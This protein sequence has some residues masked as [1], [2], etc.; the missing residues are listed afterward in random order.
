MDFCQKYDRHFIGQGRN[1]VDHARHYI[2]GLMGT[3][4]RKNMETIENDVVGSDYQGLEQ[5]I[6]SSP[7]DHRS[8]P[9]D[10]A[11]D[12]DQAIGDDTEAGF[13]LDETSFLKKGK[14]SVGV[15]RQWSGR[16]GKVEN[17]Q[18]GVFASLGRNDGFCLMDFQ[19][20][21]PES[22]AEDPDRCAKAK[23]PGDRRLYQP[24]W[25]QALDPV[26]RA[27][28][29]KGQIRLGGS[30]RPLRKQS[31]VSQRP[32]GFRRALHGGHPL[33]SQGMAGMSGA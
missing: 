11:R 30:R 9:D 32:G 18:V 29:N 16:A 21:L 19:P 7:W 24:K 10:V 1:S 5:F 33:Q 14:S 31:S 2:T 20:Y 8:L 13:F 4:R 3:Q 25:R 12:A 15:Q 17:C 27:R 23:I 28:A 6:S 26:K 22:R